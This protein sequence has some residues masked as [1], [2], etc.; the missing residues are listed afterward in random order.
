MMVRLTLRNMADGE[1]LCV[2]A[3]DPST[4]RDIPAFCRFM[5]HELLASELTKAP[6]RY[7]L[8]K[9]SEPSG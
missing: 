2:I 1:T 4:T 9:R 7:L 6:Y 8:K 3:D 5:G